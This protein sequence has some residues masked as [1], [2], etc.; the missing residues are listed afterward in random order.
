[1]RQVPEASR[2]S[3][4][5]LTAIDPSGPTSTLTMISDFCENKQLVNWFWNDASW[6][7]GFMNTLVSNRLNNFPHVQTKGYRAI[8]YVIKHIN[9]IVFNRFYRVIYLPIFS[10]KNSNKFPTL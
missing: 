6:K 1:M 3:T 8:F 7:I 10:N 5:W 2:V 9:D 4:Q